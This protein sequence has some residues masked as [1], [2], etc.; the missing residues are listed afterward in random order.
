MPGIL[1][2]HPGRGR[3]RPV[4]VASD[5][6]NPTPPADELSTAW[7]RLCGACDA[8]PAERRLPLTRDLRRRLGLPADPPEGRACP[9]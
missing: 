8:V 4:G 1:D 9:S 2:S 7:R 5:P 6:N 3:T